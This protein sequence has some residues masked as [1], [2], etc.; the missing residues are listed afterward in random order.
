MK[1]QLLNEEQG[2][3]K[4]NI[5]T[6]IIINK[7]EN[8]ENKVNHKIKIFVADLIQISMQG[9]FLKNPLWIKIKVHIISNAMDWN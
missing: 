7:E 9:H 6:G 5:I 8:N 1:K 2:K 3:N 4:N